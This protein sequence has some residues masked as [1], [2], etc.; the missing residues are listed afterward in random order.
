MS[1]SDSLRLDSVTLSSETIGKSLGFLKRTLPGPN[2]SG[3]GS[4][5]LEAW[6]MSVKV[7]PSVDCPSMIAITRWLCKSFEATPCLVQLTM[8]VWLDSTRGLVVSPT[9]L[10]TCSRTTPGKSARWFFPTE[11]FKLVCQCPERCGGVLG[12]LGALLD[13]RGAG[14]T[15]MF[16]LHAIFHEGEVGVTLSNEPDFW[17]VHF[18]DTFFG[19][20]GLGLR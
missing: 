16:L 1:K 17:P 8:L 6:S 7:S 14:L 3:S 13:G 12:G 2:S 5:S 11:A 19:F 10:K 20:L 4:T 18:V 15:S 9:Q